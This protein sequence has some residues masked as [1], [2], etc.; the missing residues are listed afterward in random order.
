VFSRHSSNCIRCTLYLCR[1]GRSHQ[2]SE[3]SPPPEIISFSLS[4][5]FLYSSSP[6]SDDTHTGKVETRDLYWLND[7]GTCI[8]SV[9]PNGYEGDTGGNVPPNT[10]FCMPYTYGGQTMWGT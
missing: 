7:D 9:E 10:P 6:S 4:D 5:I 8:G 1:H 2:A 3:P